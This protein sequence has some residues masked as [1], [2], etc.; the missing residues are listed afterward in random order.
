MV[1]AEYAKERRGEGAS[2]VDV[3]DDRLP[4]FSNR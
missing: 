3:F 2:G 4:E 1:V